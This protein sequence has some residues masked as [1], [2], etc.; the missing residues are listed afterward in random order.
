M[1]EYQKSSPALSPS[2]KSACDVASLVCQHGETFVAITQS[3][4]CMGCTARPH[5]ST[6]RHK[7]KKS[8]LKRWLFQSKSA[9]FF[10]NATT[11]WCC[12]PKPSIP[13]VIVS[14]RFKNTGAGLP[15]FFTPMPTPGG[16]PV[17]ITS[18][19]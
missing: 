13:K 6:E 3:V 9:Y 4:V 2:P 8:H 10:L 12:S 14:P 15:F 19:G 5:R 17:Q 18:P 1:L 7:S 16:V 11:F